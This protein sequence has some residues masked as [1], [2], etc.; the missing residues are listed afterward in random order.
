MEQGYWEKISACVTHASSTL[1]WLAALPG[2]TEQLVDNSPRDLSW[3]YFIAEIHRNSNVVS[4][5]SP[6]GCSH[7]NSFKVEN[8]KQNLRVIYQCFVWSG[9]AE[10]RKR[11]VNKIHQSPVVHCIG[12][13]FSMPT[14][15]NLSKANRRVIRNANAF[16]FIWFIFTKAMIPGLGC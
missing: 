16:C 14:R 12:P 4:V 5:M 6:A 13:S 3:A 9:S 2:K 7:V 1:S 15:I 10:T 8:W 11:K